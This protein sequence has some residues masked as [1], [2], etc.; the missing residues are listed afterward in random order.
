[1]QPYEIE[2]LARQIRREIEPKIAA[3][4][5]Q[6]EAQIEE[7]SAFWKS[8]PGMIR[9]TLAIGSPPATPTPAP[10]AP[11]LEPS[12]A[13]KLEAMPPDEFYK[14]MQSDPKGL[15]ARLAQADQEG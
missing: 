9:E 6:M 11:A 3:T 7:M 2:R 5:A 8:Y 14:V 1:M 12:L 10:R 15:L 13:E 4:T